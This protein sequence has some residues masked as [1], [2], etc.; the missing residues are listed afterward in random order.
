MFCN[1][2]IN[3]ELLFIFVFCFY[4]AFRVKYVLN[5]G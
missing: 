4:R 5:T 2:D 1:E 3:E